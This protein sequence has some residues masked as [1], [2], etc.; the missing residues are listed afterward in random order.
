[1][2]KPTVS[3]GNKVTSWQFS[4]LPGN[5][6]SW[7]ICVQGVQGI[8]SYGSWLF[9]HDYFLHIPESKYFQKNILLLYNERY[10]KG[11]IW[12]RDYCIARLPPPP[13]PHLEFPMIFHWVNVD[14]HCHNNHDNTGINRMCLDSTL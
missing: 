5:F 14:V 1:M 8:F 9:I 3:S 13:P 12:Y 11:T 6:V 10:T 7:W 4:P 2:A